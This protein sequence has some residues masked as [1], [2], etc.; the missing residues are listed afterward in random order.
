M[1]GKGADSDPQKMRMKLLIQFQKQ[2][3]STQHNA[4]Y[5]EVGIK[6]CQ[7]ISM[8]CYAEVGLS[9]LYR[10]RRV[11]CVKFIAIIGYRFTYCLQFFYVC[12]KQFQ[13]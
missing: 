6:M 10:R 12:S 5:V 4:R 8:L 7:H 3:I 1:N 2:S 9:E 13:N 11:I